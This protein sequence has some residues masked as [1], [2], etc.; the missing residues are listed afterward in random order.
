MNK[1]LTVIA[2]ATAILAAGC[3]GQQRA[4]APM[5][6]TMT[7]VGGESGGTSSAAFRC[8]IRRE[9]SI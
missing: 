3:A 9:R 4:S 6:D 7:G 8:S 1:R 2:L 5:D